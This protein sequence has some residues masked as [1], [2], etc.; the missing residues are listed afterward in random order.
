M[1]SVR[2]TRPAPFH[3]NEGSG[4]ARELEAIASLPPSGEET[5]AVMEYE[6]YLGVNLIG[7]AV[8]VLIF[9]FHYV[10]SDPPKDLVE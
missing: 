5:K 3:F 9:F 6:V 8:M 4:F 7:A 1:T 10:A 2:A